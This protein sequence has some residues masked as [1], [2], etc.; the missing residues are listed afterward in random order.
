M[1]VLS[2]LIGG[3]F[4]DGGTGS[5]TN[6]DASSFEDSE[7]AQTFVVVALSQYRELHEARQPRGVP[8]QFGTD[9][10][11]SIS[12]DENGGPSVGRLICDKIVGGLTTG[13]KLRKMPRG[14]RRRGKSGPVVPAVTR[15]DRRIKRREDM[16]TI[17]SK[18][19]AFAS[20]CSQD[21]IIFYFSFS[22]RSFQL[23]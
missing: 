9:H 5:N 6:D 1:L 13:W 7:F 8:G 21:V 22:R 10:Y 3:R 23:K 4:D 2:S 16:R 14:R 18:C 17:R 15:E 11:E 12:E 20:V 19:D